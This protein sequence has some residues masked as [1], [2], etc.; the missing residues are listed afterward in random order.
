MAKRK[1]PQ[2][3]FGETDDNDEDFYF[4]LPNTD[5]DRESD[6]YCSDS[7]SDIVPVERPVRELTMSSDSETEENDENENKQQS[8]S[9]RSTWNK[10]IDVTKEE[11]TAFLGVVLNMGTIPVPN[12]QYYW[13]KDHIG[14]I[15]FFRDTFRRER[16]FQ[17]FWMLHLNENISTNRNVSTR[18]QKVSNFLD[19]IG[20]KFRAY[21]TPDR[22][23]SIDES[24][25]KFKGK[26][27]FITYNPKKPTKWGIRIYVLIL[28]DSHTGYIYAMLPYYGS[29]TTEILIR[30]DL[31]VSSRIVLQLYHT[32]L[33]AN[34]EAKGYHIFTDRFFTGI[35]LAQELLKLNCYLTGTINTNRKYIPAM[36]KKPALTKN[37]IVAAYRS[38]AILLLAWR[39]KRIVTMLSSYNT[40]GTT[41]TERRKK[42]AG[43]VNIVK[44][45]VV[46]NYNTNMGGVDKADQL[47]SSYCF[48]RKS[49]KWWRK[50]FFWGLEICA[51]N[52]YILYKV[53]ARRESR[54]P[55]PHFM[56]VRKLVAQL[57]G[58][59]RG[60]ADSKPGRPSTSDKD[61]RLNGKLHIL[62]HCEN[63]K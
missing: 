2:E 61:E 10:W 12:M 21:F 18:I 26:I 47:A 44:P 58:N 34:P 1:L 39:D 56:F 42:Q 20:D 41:I 62:R 7:D 40:S 11:L 32:L 5:S 4:G 15:P 3:V 36:I 63:V 9:T 49:C 59:F 31:P 16:F 35:P 57:V 19:Y 51:I 55:M 46:I 33:T 23:I 30:P 38:G 52:S 17:I 48:M 60:G 13:T 6:N 53:S 25:V 28:S 54:K 8:L 24:V 27:S 14:N 37:N 22:E 29:V 50:L 43:T 45:N